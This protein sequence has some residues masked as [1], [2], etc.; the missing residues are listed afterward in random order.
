MSALI[1]PVEKLHQ[2]VVRIK[3]RSFPPAAGGLVG[4]SCAVRQWCRAGL[5]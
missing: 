2:C 5:K 3:L 4:L 1:E